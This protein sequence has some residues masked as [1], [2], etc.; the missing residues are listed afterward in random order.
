MLAP[1]LPLSPSLPPSP[2]Y[3]LKGLSEVL[4]KFLSPS[5]TDC[6]SLVHKPFLLLVIVGTLGSDIQY[7]LHTKLLQHLVGGR[8][9]ERGREGGREG[10]RRVGGREGGRGREGGERERGGK[11]KRR[12]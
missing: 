9:E 1:S 10:G 11:G 4:G 12:G 6:Y 3:E 8:R 2:T 5:V 7:I